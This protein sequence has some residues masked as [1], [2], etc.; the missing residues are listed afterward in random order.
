MSYLTSHFQVAL[1]PKS[2]PC[3]KEVTITFVSNKMVLVST[4]YKLQNGPHLQQQNIALKWQRVDLRSQ[5]TNK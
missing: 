4:K 5:Q 1:E 3:A 2:E